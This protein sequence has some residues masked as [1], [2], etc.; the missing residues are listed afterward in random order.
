MWGDEGVLGTVIVE[1]IESSALVVRLLRCC[2]SKD[3]INR[4]WVDKLML[5][6]TLARRVQTEK[7]PISPIGLQMVNSHS[8]IK[9]AREGKQRKPS[10]NRT[11]TG[12]KHLGTA[13][14]DC[15][16]RRRWINMRRDRS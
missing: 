7:G 12:G 6:T 3:Q 11:R 13:A 16:A 9:S 1:V 8:G 4:E 10:R 14:P 2:R 5:Y 15:F